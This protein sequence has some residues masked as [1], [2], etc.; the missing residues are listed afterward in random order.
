MRVW[1][2]ERKASHSAFNGSFQ[3]GPRSDGLAFRLLGYGDAVLP[4]DGVG[5]ENQ[6]LFDGFR[7]IEDEH[8]VAPHDDELLLLKGVEPAYEDVSNKSWGRW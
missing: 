8:A 7:I 1:I 2:A 5:I 3:V 4:I 6:F